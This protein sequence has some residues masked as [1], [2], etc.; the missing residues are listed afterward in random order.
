M[1]D[2]RILPAIVWTASSRRIPAHLKCITD[3]P[4][5]DVCTTLDRLCDLL[6]SYRVGVVVWDVT[7]AQRSQLERILDRLHR[8]SP[9][10]QVILCVDLNRHTARLLSA[11]ASLDHQPQLVMKG[12]DDL[13]TVLDELDEGASEARAHLTI[14]RHLLPSAPTRGKH[15]VAPAIVAGHRRVSPHEFAVL[16]AL[17][18]RTLEWQ[19]RNAH[20]PP[21]RRLLGVMLVL[22]GLWRL[23]YLGWSTKRVAHYSGFKSSHSW[24]NFIQ[25][26]AGGRPADLLAEGGFD[27][28]VIWAARQLRY[29][30]SDHSSGVL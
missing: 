8:L 10:V 7:P 14:A 12:F 16:C 18:R 25:R 20:L 4:G 19:L 30:S 22:H 26:H 27:A 6:E 2:A 3:R 15:L 28:S 21:P 5:V 29:G 23:D 1:R 24:G 11:L 9:G 17:A 13:A